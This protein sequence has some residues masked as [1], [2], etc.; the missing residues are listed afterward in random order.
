LLS[1]LFDLITRRPDL[2]VDHAV[3]YVDLAQREFA[4]VRQRTLRQA[5]AC[6][7]VL[8]LAITFLVLCG[9]AALL[10]IAGVVA[11]TPGVFAV[12][13]VFL[14]AVIGVGWY[15]SS[16]GADEPP[17]NLRLQIDDDLKLIREFSECRA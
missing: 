7:A 15:A 6:L 8:A 14:L 17:G 16:I 10:C 4:Q 11:L 13:A 1:R 3:A 9:V 2:L 5:I 12:P